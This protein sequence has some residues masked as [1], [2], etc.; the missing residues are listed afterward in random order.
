[1]DTSTCPTLPVERVAILGLGL[2]GTSL[3]MALRRRG[4]ARAVAGYDLAPRVA[5]RAHACGAVTAVCGAVEDAVAAADLVVIATPVLAV[6]A[7]MAACA[8]SLAPA[9]VVT[10]VCSTKA[11][12]VRWAE[13]L[14]PAPEHFIGG[15]PM[16][17][18]ETSGPDAADA[19]LFAGCVWCLAPTHRCDTMALAWLREL[20]AA[21]GARPLVLDA[22][23]H[24]EA[25]AAI[26]HLP[27][28]A[29]AAL[30]L[31]AASD[32]RADLARTLAASGF[33]DTT[34]VASGSPRMGRDILL[35]NREPVLACLDAYLA[36]LH[37]LRDAIARSDGD[38]L[39]R[40]LSEARRIRGEWMKA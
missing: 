21:L 36:Q 14:L 26:S 32:A 33:R 27:L 1:M 40:T 29:A 28:V 22:V 37:H 17:G 8:A 35:T 19:E 20:V 9:A 34:R 5:A 24:D 6:S 30:T 25:V 10:D 2:M 23:E 18:R 38:A 39:E 7:V 12:V 13:E 4:L 3:G 16:A 31:T 11:E 15:H